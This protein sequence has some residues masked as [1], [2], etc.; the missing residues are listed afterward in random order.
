MAKI[1]IDNG[2]GKLTAGKRTPPIP[3]TNKVI[4]EWEFNYPT[5]LKLKTILEKQGHQILMVSDTDKDTPLKT[6]T[7]KA[8]AWGADIFVSLHYNAENEIFDKLVEGIET[9]YNSFSING[10]R[11][12]ELVQTELI[13]AT[14]LR[15][16]GVKPR[17]DLHVLNATK[18]VAIIA[19]C[20]FMDNVR[21]ANLM[22][23]ND[24]QQRCALAVSNAINMYLGV[25]PV[26]KGGSVVSKPVIPAQ[27]PIQNNSPSA[28]A[29]EAWNWAKQQG[30]LDGTRPRDPVTREELAIILK[31]LADKKLI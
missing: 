18:M 4:H 25:K 11:L 9:L 16:R 7:D 23:N 17:S 28:W 10:K 8:N 19:E 21:E 1:A 24:H 15:N 29:V 6:R 3:G 14:G 5:A 2:H 13:K 27:V 20:G 26:D 22:L 12:A 31:R 30:L